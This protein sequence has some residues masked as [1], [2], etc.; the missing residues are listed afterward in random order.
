[1]KPMVGDAILYHDGRDTYAA[2]VTR[3]EEDG[4]IGLAV[5]IDDAPNPHTLVDGYVKF[6]K[7]VRFAETPKKGEDWPIHSW[8]RP[9]AA[10]HFN[11]ESLV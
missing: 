11:A 3:V 2:I 1:M 9:D 6:L 4:K 5:F 7:G 8:S 10:T